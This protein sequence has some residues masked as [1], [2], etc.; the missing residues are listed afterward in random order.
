M[1]GLTAMS[2]L[3]SNGLEALGYIDKESVRF[4]FGIGLVTGMML[5]TFVNGLA[6]FVYYS[7]KKIIEVK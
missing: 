6:C 1:L 3:I 4:V 7:K 2:M 5:I